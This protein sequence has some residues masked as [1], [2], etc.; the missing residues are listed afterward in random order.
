[1][2]F[3]ALLWWA[4]GAEAACS[5]GGQTFSCTAGSTISDANSAISSS[6]DG[7]TITFAPG[8]Y[9]WTNGSITPSNDKGVTLMCQNVGT[10]TVTIASNSVIYMDT[11][12]GNNTK[13]YRVSG[14]TFQNGNECLCIWFAGNGTLHNLRIDH[15]TFRNFTTGA[16]AVFFGAIGVA[17]KYYGVIDHNTLTGATNFMFSKILG[18]GG[19]VDTNWGSSPRGTISNMFFEDNTI[20][21][22][23]ISNLGAACLD[24]WHSSA[25]VWRYNNTTNC[26]LGA[27]GVSHGGVINYEIYKNT[28]IR[29]EGSGDWTDCTRCIHHQGSGEFYVWDNAFK[30]TS[31]STGTIALL[32]YRSA[33]PSEAGYNAL[34]G[35]C[36]GTSPIDGNW[37][38][39]STYYGYPCWRQ[40]GRNGN[41]ELN[42]IYTWNNRWSDNGAQVNLDIQNPW[43]T[44][45]PS[46]FDHVKPNRDF[47]DA[48][49]TNAQ[50]SPTSP[51]SGTFGMGFGTLANRPT[52]CTTNPNESGGGV[53]YFATDQGSQGALYRCSAA[54]TWTL[55][56]T[57]YTYPHPLQIA[58]KVGGVT[59]GGPPLPSA[60]GNLMVR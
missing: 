44:T 48:V 45:S 20:G 54:N 32:H 10:C 53:G 6:T 30:G 34:L 11:L 13:L 31:H 19:A 42:P 1:M 43:S 50:T 46:V 51:F 35:R 26:R 49:S 39:Q 5:G 21:F 3:F 25:V 58:V 55:H 27:H 17:G 15:N 23:S 9:T 41:R 56:Y 7:A 18:H 57:P 24:M 36:D 33:T 16:I 14:F 22:T 60:P 38:P 37:A 47:Y 52:A 59:G 12:S 29:S 8:S 28:I 4:A 40:P 2:F